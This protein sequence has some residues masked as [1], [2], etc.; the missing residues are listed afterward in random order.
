MYLKIQ[1]ILL[2]LLSTFG[3]KSC[4]ENG[5]QGRNENLMMRVNHFKQTGIG[6]GK[7]LVYLVQEAG[8]IGG[9]QWNFMYEPI[10]G[11]DFEP[12]YVYDLR[13]KKQAVP[14]PPQDGSSVRYILLNVI[15]KTPVPEDENFDIR[16][17]WGGENFVTSHGEDPYLLD[18]YLIDCNSLCSELNNALQNNEEVT[19]TFS[20]GPDSS[21]KLISLE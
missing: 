11:F 16:L 13:L 20:H 7:H 6:E 17:K 5:L 12:G 14:N 8:E 2:A 4:S 15:S 1:I 3:L 10:E 18:E 19:G 9:E 21:L